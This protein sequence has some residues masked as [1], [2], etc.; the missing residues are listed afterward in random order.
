M[1]EHQLNKLQIKA[2]V[3]TV[4]SELQTSLERANIEEVLKTLIIQDDKK[5]ILDILIKE[6]TRA[7]EQ[8]AILICFL[9][10]KLCSEIEPVN[11]LEDAL[12]NTLKNPSVT[13]AIK[14]IILNVL[15]DMGNK[16]DYEKLEEYFENPN[17]VI[18][19]D[20]QKLLQAAII[21]PEAQIDFLDFVNSLSDMDRKVLV[22]S[23]GE[24]YSSD[25]LANILNP[26]VL[27]DPT[28]ELG[29]IAIDILG[30]T[31]SQLA[32]H[33][34]TEALDPNTFIDD[35]VTIALI[36]KNI[37]KLKIS[38]VREDNAIE[39][40]RGILE[41]KPYCAY[42]SY[43][44]GHGNQAIIFSRE[45]EIEKGDTIQIVALVINDTYGLVDCFGF[46]E[47]SKAEFERIVDRFYN[48]DEHIYL[49]PSVIKTI[50]L[51]AEKLT[52]KVSGKVSYEYLCWK[53]LLADI[54]A[55]PVPIE[56]ILKSQFEQQPL[57]DDELE[58]IYMFD[59]IQR[60]FFDTDYNEEFKLLI[61]NLNS[62]ISEDDANINF[63]SVVKENLDRIFSTEQKNILNKRILMSAY[64]KYLS[65][66]LE[67]AQL[68]YSLYFDEDKKSKLA[69]NIIRKSIYEYYVLLKF[70]YK[71]EHKMT[72]IFS[73]RNKQKTSELNPK[74]I[75]STISQIEKL[76]V[77]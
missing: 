59:F 77:K 74:Q 58:Q 52:R 36:K 23:L 66:D 27:Y 72:N 24:D 55:E 44:D 49:N 64:L 15:K 22:Q 16:V 42:T 5:T 43:P 45:R 53:A 47:I 13:D 63:E 4:L 39:F 40:Y 60:W 29:K 10:L 57:I 54:E 71:E 38:G 31:K 41:S 28:C 32:L 30:T 46:N 20:T 56:H 21:N 68:L 34:L 65:G 69:E 6:L 12:W 2:E 70:K 51:N 7:N 48:N 17:E 8:K 75:D 35:E 33:T 19:A 67:D 76:W 61:S 62:K 26:L 73:M 18:D 1:T 9:L 11:T 25:N 3:L 37:S 14:A 50:L